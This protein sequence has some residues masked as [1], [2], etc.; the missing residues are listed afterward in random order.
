MRMAAPKCSP[1]RLHAWQPRKPATR[2][3][4]PSARAR[5]RRKGA[6]RTPPPHGLRRALQRC[7]IRGIPT[8]C[9]GLSFAQCD[10]AEVL[11]CRFS[12]GLVHYWLSSLAILRSA[13]RRDAA[14][15]SLPLLPLRRPGGRHAL[16]LASFLQW[17]HPRLRLRV[18]ACG[19]QR[20]QPS[21]LGNTEDLRNARL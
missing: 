19:M 1:S 18:L 14:S 12:R 21:R 7:P 3:A 10:L 5:S 20:A 15:L 8:A 4:R 11:Q 6:L 17:R 9:G 16:S 13:K 2:A